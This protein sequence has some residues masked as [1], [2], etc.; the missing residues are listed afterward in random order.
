M[1]CSR[2]VGFTVVS[3]CREVWYLFTTLSCSPSR[4]SWKRIIKGEWTSDGS[5]RT[6]TYRGVLGSSSCVDDAKHRRTT[7]DRVANY[8]AL[9]Q[10]L[11]QA[12]IKHSQ[13]AESAAGEVWGWL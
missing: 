4:V 2:S 8:Y 5:C 6:R 1:P 10:E 7:S 9:L 3:P 11:E 12:R 13:V